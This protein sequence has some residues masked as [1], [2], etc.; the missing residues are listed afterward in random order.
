MLIP[1]VDGEGREGSRV[2]G[3]RSALSVADEE[4]AQRKAREFLALTSL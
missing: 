2:G 4:K 3:R 1:A